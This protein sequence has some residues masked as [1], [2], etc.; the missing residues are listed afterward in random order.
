MGQVP[1]DIVILGNGRLARHLRFFLSAQAIPFRFWARK[2]EALGI[3]PPFT[4]AVAG[5]THCLLAVSD[6][7]ISELAVRIRVIAPTASQVHFSGVRSLS[8]LWT[9]HPLMTFGESLYAADF[10]PSIPF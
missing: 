2:E 4:E 8:G 5:A 3:C 6:R 1:Y 9:A 10:Y 7:A